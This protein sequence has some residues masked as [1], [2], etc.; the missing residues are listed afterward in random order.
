MAQREFPCPQCRA[1]ILVPD[2]YFQAAIACAYCAAVVDRRTGRAINPVG[3]NPYQAPVYPGNAALPPGVAPYQGYA[4]PQPVKRKSTGWIIAIIVAA[5]VLP[6]VGV[7]ALAA[8]PLFVKNENAAKEEWVKHVD[9][10]GGFEVLF[11][12]TPRKASEPIDT[13]LGSRTFHRA[14]CIAYRMHFEASYF[15]LGSGH[16]SEYVYDYEDAAWAMADYANGE[17]VSQTPITIS[18]HPATR[19]LMSTSGELFN[20]VVIVRKGNR[21]FI[22]TCEGHGKDDGSIAERFLH[23][24]QLIDAARRE[25]PRPS[26]PSYPSGSARDLQPA[27]PSPGPSLSLTSIVFDRNGTPGEV[28]A[29]EYSIFGGKT[30]Y[31]F[32]FERGPDW[33]TGAVNGDRLVLTGTPPK[34]GVYPA[35]V[36]I[37][38]ANN[39]STW[40]RFA[41]HVK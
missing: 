17:V 40:D 23:S 2:D 39:R 30:P 15:D 5:V 31:T 22:A 14:R 27:P 9:H 12:R 8:I 25:Q 7:L 33:L 10:A 26:K 16:V 20:S 13:P 3:A 1:V 29:A 32:E 4:A 36:K 34:K 38:D 21:V 6:V 18:G 37:T 28:W 24:F 41:I 35:A 11:P 19:A